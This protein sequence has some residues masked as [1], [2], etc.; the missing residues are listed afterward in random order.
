MDSSRC[1]RYLGFKEYALYAQRA[2]KEMLRQRPEPVYDKDGMLVSGVLIRHL[3]LPCN[4]DQ[5]KRL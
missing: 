3:V 4:V 5:S 2:I 1:G